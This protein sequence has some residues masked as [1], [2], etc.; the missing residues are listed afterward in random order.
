MANEFAMWRRIK[1]TRCAIALSHL[2]S[3]V[4]GWPRTL[5][6]GVNGFVSSQ[7]TRWV[8]NQ[9]SSWIRCQTRGRGVASTPPPVP[10]RMSKCRVAARVKVRLH[11]AY[12]VRN[13]ICC[14]GDCAVVLLLFADSRLRKN[15]MVCL[16]WH[17]TG[18]NT[19]DAYVLSLLDIFGSQTSNF[20]LSPHSIISELKGLTQLRKSRRIYPKYM[21]KCSV[22]ST[23]HVCKFLLKNF[24]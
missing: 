7:A 4:I 12:K 24:A 21:P 1:S 23:D 19:T 8:L 13:L 15:A 14:I 16:R 18:L 17:G 20:Y 2:T 11:Y 10:W 5:N 22:G 9:S 6:S 3:E